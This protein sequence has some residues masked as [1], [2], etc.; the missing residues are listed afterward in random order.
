M[1]TVYSGTI[2]GAG[3]SKVPPFNSVRSQ[4]YNNNRFPAETMR[5]NAVTEI[6]ELNAD[7]MIDPISNLVDRAVIILSSQND[8]HVPPKNQEAARQVFEN[9]NT[10]SL[11]LQDTGNDKHRLGEDYAYTMLD[12]LYTNLGYVQDSSEFRSNLDHDLNWRRNGTWTTFDQTEFFDGVDW[13]SED[14]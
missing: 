14:L 5:D 4:F 8:R 10:G 13:N 3:C 9:Y 7:R 6:D 12:Y 2:K 11:Q 1:M